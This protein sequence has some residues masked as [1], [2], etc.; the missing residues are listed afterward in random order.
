[1]ACGGS[2]SDRR[3]EAEPRPRVAQLVSHLDL[4]LEKRRRTHSDPC[5]L[6]AH[7]SVSL[8]SRRVRSAPDMKDFLEEAVA[9]IQV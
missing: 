9:E 3:A 4:P 7:P 2:T 1:M 8:S 5:E 6:L